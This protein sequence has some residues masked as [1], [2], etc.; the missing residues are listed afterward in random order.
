M[1]A[2]AKPLPVAPPT[3][4]SPVRYFMFD[5]DI[6]AF[7]NIQHAFEFA[8]YSAFMTGRTLVLPP[9]APMWMKDWGPNSF[10]GDLDE[11]DGWFSKMQQGR[12][13]NY[14][15]RLRMPNTTSRLEDYF[16]MSAPK[17]LGG[18]VPVVSF[19]DFLSLERVRLGLPW[20]ENVHL[21]SLL[22]AS[23][24]TIMRRQGYRLE[25]QYAKY[26]KD[27]QRGRYFSER[28]KHVCAQ[29][30]GVP[31]LQLFGRQHFW[32][33]RDCEVP[34]RHEHETHP[35]VYFPNDPFL[36]SGGHPNNYTRSP[37]L[38]VCVRQRYYIPR[39][40]LWVRSFFRYKPN[41]LAMAD[42]VISLLGGARSY[43]G[44]H[45]RAREFDQHNVSDTPERLAS[46]MESVA[47]CAAL[48]RPVPLYVA[49][50]VP[51]RFAPGWPH[52][53]RLRSTFWGDVQHLLTSL[54]AAS[55][56]SSPQVWSKISGLVESEVIT[57][58][59]AF[60]GTGKSTFTEEVIA[61]VKH[62]GVPYVFHQYGLEQLSKKECIAWR[63]AAIPMVDGNRG[64]T[65][66]KAKPKG[67]S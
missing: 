44:L 18:L 49:T 3:T 28:S 39:F 64:H 12:K 15:R 47:D 27:S 52:A 23:E 38:W 56:Y 40:W 20:P 33:P 65:P 9:P 24:C 37:R 14:L 8:A 21:S 2:K 58:A 17:G 45:Y 26:K 19:E 22:T 61:K 59:G 30:P 25:A 31:D 55:G 60:I 42:R 50:D 4:K 46:F 16:D 43:L 48:V 11:A 1:T 57:S 5:M 13:R 32:T 35:V 36:G 7:T 67:S 29:R 51:E 34:A 63:R 6:G 53:P 54:R 62:E 10:L 41:I 66:A